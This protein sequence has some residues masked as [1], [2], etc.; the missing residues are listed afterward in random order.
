MKLKIVS[1]CSSFP[2]WSG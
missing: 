1:R 2:S